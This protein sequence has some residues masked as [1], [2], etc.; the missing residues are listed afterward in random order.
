M[1]LINTERE[2]ERRG[3]EEGGKRKEE[4]QE[5]Q[6]TRSVM[7]VE[8]GRRTFFFF[9]HSVSPLLSVLSSFLSPKRRKCCERETER[10][11]E[12]T[13]TAANG[14][15]QRKRKSPR[16]EREERRKGREKERGRLLTQKFSPENRESL[17]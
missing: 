13:I 16:R 15:C 7:K 17:T 12:K 6:G 2:R 9:K 3:R 8:T 10:E 4:N 5:K 14:E 1:P 11:R